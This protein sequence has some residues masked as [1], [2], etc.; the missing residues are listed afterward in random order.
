MQI[1][2]GLSIENWNII[3]ALIKEICEDLGATTF[4]NDSKKGKC[5]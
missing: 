4:C 3:V 1:L 5:E 2:I